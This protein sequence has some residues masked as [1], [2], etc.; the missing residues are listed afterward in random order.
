MPEIKQRYSN[1]E[2]IKYTLSVKIADS[3]IIP[4]GYELDY[5]Y[6]VKIP[7]KVNGKNGNIGVVIDSYPPNEVFEYIELVPSGARVI[8]SLR[9]L[10][11]KN[12][13]FRLLTGIGPTYGRIVFTKSGHSHTRNIRSKNDFDRY[14]KAIEIITPTSPGPH[15]LISKDEDE[16]GITYVFQKLDKSERKIRLIKE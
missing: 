1:G 4:A 9:N 12:I 10:K 14:K 5:I 2:A 15:H 6:I 7:D 16:S 3:K 8:Q 11:N 13:L